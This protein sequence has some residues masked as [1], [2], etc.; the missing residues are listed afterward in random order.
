[1]QHSAQK[2]NVSP[3]FLFFG[4]LFRFLILALRIPK[5]IREQAASGAFKKITFAPRPS[6]KADVKRSP[7]RGFESGN[8]FFGRRDE[9]K[10]A[11]QIIGRAEGENA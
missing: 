4:K 3:H 8:D 6:C 7:F 2:R 1:V 5:I 9:T 11:R 10:T